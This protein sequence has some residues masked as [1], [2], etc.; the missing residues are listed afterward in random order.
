MALL[1]FRRYMRNFIFL[2]ALLP[3][4][5]FSQGWIP[6][7]ARSGGLLNASTTLTD[8]WSYFNNPGALGAIE[9]FSSGVSYESRFLL[10]DLQRQSLAIAIPTKL[11]VFSIGAFNQGSSEFRNFRSGVG[12]ALKLAD[13]FSAGVQINYQ[14]LRLPDYYGKSRT[15]TGEVGVLLNVTDKWDF[16]FAVFNLGQNK[17]SDFQNDRY[18]TTLR[19]GTSYKPANTIKIIAEV[20][21]DIDGP[22]SFK[23]ALEYEPFKQFYMRLGAGNQPSALAFGFGYK[24]KEFSLNIATAYH[25]VLGWSPQISFTY[26]KRNGK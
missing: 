20:W 5:V 16:G 24:W 3:I 6:T 12:Y 26:E 11:G 21:K 9:N 17:L 23:G 14:G 7:G 4:T 18:N 1:I 13:H 15:I 22:V 8:N 25:Q 10:S 19:L 2:L